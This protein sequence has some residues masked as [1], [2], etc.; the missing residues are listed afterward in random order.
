MRW[1]LLWGLVLALL[2]GGCRTKA[3]T[4]G[5]EE[6]QL[7]AQ[8]AEI[9]TE[10]TAIVNA[11]RGA[12]NAGDWAQVGDLGNQQEDLFL[13]LIETEDQLAAL[14]ATPDTDLSSL[15]GLEVPPPLPADENDTPE[16]RAKVDSL[17]V[18]INL[19]EE[20][21]EDAYTGQDQERIHELSQKR[22]S[23]IQELGDLLGKPASG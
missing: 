10:L 14:G 18:V 6:Q 23:Y 17:W 11:T 20:A 8:Y 4:P 5:Y 15:P 22:E 9:A 3:N 2:A 1:I 19:C 12:V 16:G 7:Q 13:A 21:I